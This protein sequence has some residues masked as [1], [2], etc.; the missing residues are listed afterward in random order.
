MSDTPKEE[1]RLNVDGQWFMRGN[2]SNAWFATFRED[3]GLAEKVPPEMW[4]VFEALAAALKAKEHRVYKACPKHQDRL[5]L[6]Y[7][8]TV[9]TVTMP[10]PAVEVCPHCEQEAMKK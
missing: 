5:W 7:Q 6:N 9:T 3:G 1:V 8:T 4:P 10:A 2:V